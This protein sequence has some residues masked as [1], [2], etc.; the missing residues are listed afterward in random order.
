MY[1]AWQLALKYFNYYIS[2]SNG[3]GHGIHSPFIFD[4][5]KKVL[6]D[7]AVYPAYGRLDKIREDLLHDNT[8]I[9]LEDLGAGSVVSKT[10]TRTIATIARHSAKSKKFAC[11]LYR[12]VQH[13]KPTPI[14]EL[15][16]SL[17]L[18]TAG[19]AMADPK[20]TIYT[21]E[22]AASV[23]GIAKKN[24]SQLGIENIDL[25]VGH[26]DQ[27]LPLLLADLNHVGLAF[28]D[29]NHQYEPTLDYFRQLLPKMKNDSILIFDDIHWSTGMEQAWQGIQQ[30]P[31]VR[32]TVD[33]FFIGIVFFREE[34]REKQHFTIRY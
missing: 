18:C 14:V 11:L 13:Y 4:F 33:L 20:A 7:D 34:F 30:D 15:G 29:G 12:I 26:F 31:A 27:Q 2:A 5:I 8:S 10:N 6:N 19:F 17:G 9:T 21:I 28:I 25:R 16:T 32:C 3:K 22:G 24:F 1:N 23:A